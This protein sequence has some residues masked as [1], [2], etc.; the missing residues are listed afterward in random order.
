MGSTE[1]VQGHSRF[2]A[3]G[4]IRT[5]E[6]HMEKKRENGTGSGCIIVVSEPL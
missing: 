4:T 3:I 5:M 2:L 1:T 6:V